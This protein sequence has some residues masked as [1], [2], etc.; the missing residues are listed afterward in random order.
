[1]QLMSLEG[2]SRY[3]MPP[4]VK[5]KV[6]L[7]S[8]GEIRERIHE[9]QH[10]EGERMRWASAPSASSLEYHSAV[11]SHHHLQASAGPGG[12]WV[13]ELGLNTR[14]PPL[15]RSLPPPAIVLFPGVK[16]V[17]ETQRP[18]NQSCLVRVLRHGFPVVGLR[19]T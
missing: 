18:G 19:H 16:Q 3:Q 13:S 7:L 17:S 9:T 5:K 15:M 6:C 4:L 11:S 2:Q 1:M 10:A 12:L 14:P 8:L